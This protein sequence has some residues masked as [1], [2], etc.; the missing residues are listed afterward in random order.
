MIYLHAFITWFILV[1][2]AIINGSIRN[3][4]YQPYAGE[5]PAHQISTIIF[6]LLILAA[7]YVFLSLLKKT[8]TKTQL[9][10]IGLFWLVL[11][12]LF[13]FIFQHYVMAKSWQVL[14]ADY[15]FLQGRIWLLV[16]IITFLAPYLSSK[17]ISKYK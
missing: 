8:L 3:F 16:L 13:E 12:I 5:L 9:I 14:L 4:I 15:N 7:A 2:L 11:T 10:L 17:F 1:I 6:C